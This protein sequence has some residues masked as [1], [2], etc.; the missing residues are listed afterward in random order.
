MEE[1]FCKH[2]F[3]IQQLSWLPAFKQGGKGKKW[4][5]GAKNVRTMWKKHVTSYLRLLQFCMRIGRKAGGRG[6]GKGK[7]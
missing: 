6:D 3:G 2:L 1:E 7:P 4:L 5:V